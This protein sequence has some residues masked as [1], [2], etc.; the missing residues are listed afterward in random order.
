MTTQ[1]TTLPQPAAKSS[2]CGGDAADNKAKP[3]V[4]AKPGAAPAPLAKAPDK[5]VGSC[6]GGG[7]HAKV[8]H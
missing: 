2:C 5:A 6:C 3:T 4:A 7:S 1:T 8:D